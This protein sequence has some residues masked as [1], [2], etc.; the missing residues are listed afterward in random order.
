[1]LAQGSFR[2]VRL[3]ARFMA[4]ATATVLAFGLVNY[5]LLDAVARRVLEAEV[6]EHALA[7]A[8]KLAAVAAGAAR[9]GKAD[10]LRASLLL[11]TRSDPDFGYALVVARDGTLRAST[12]S[13]VPPQLLDANRP[14]PGTTA[15]RPVSLGGAGYLDVAAP[16]P[17]GSGW[18]RVGVGEG[19]LRSSLHFI[20]LTLLAMVF[21]FLVA[22]LFGA[23]LL[24]RVVA[25]PV[26]QLAEAVRTFDPAHPGPAPRVDIPASGEV[27]DLVRSFDA[28]AA[29]L[30]QLHE[31]QQ[32]F[33][34]RIVRAERLAT[35]GALAAG[36]A[37][38]VGNPLAGMRNCL[39]AIAR[40]PEDVEQTRAYAGMMVDA[41]LAIE[42]AVRSLVDAA[43]RSRPVEGPVD[44][45]SLC[46]RV[47]L[48]L[49]HRF[50]AAGVALELDVH[51]LPPE[52][53]T[54]EGSVQQVLVNLLINACDAA[55]RAT[56]VALRARCSDEWIA[57]EVEDHG[58]GIDPALRGR[59]FEP[60]VTT[61]ASSGG[62]GLGLAMVQRL[63]SE[64]G[65][66]VAF[67]SEPGKGTRFTV[68]L[69]RAAQ[70]PVR[71]DAA[72]ARTTA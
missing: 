65:G 16:I 8:Q 17:G 15:S 28:M 11:A 60:F 68:K 57:F 41:T 24:A 58:A 56:Q 38:D 49:R 48:L 46:R 34:S 12:L 5:L 64:M 50:A 20:R 71:A 4:L 40:E 7:H 59:I 72:P 52:I 18:V 6:V 26:E 3:R 39:R 29:R 43:A 53:R 21:A 70:A 19:H 44:I 1:M 61:K 42:R 54:D 25:A 55:P 67:D 22:G 62:T 13:H 51:E 31:E 9:E 30:R 63:V 45:A 66:T 47:R 14:L 10:E 32:E 2:R 69:P 35:V 33:Q 37:H 23:R 36:I 27:A